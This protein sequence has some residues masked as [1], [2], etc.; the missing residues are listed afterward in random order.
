MTEKWIFN[1]EAWAVGTW[2]GYVFKI[3]CVKLSKDL[4]NHA[5]KPDEVIEPVRIIA[6]DG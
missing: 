5:R 1:P 3:R 2:V 4:A 6:D